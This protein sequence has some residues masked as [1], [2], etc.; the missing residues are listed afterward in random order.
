MV[1][2]THPGTNRQGLI[3]LALAAGLAAASLGVARY[4]QAPSDA[5]AEPS[6]LG[7]AGAAGADIA[8]LRRTAEAAPDD[9]R[10]WGNLAVAHAERGEFTAAVAAFRRATMI[11][12][13]QPALWS[14]LGEAL[15]M[16]S[17]GD[18]LPPAALDAFKKAL[19]LDPKDTRA[20]YF[21]AAKKDIDKDHA[22]A[23]ADWLALLADTPRGA[24]WEADLLRTIEQVGKANGISVASRIAAVNAKRPAGAPAAAQRGPSADDAAAAASMT[25][26]EQRTMIEGMVGQLEARL[27]SEAQNPE[28]WVML[29]RSRMAL[30]E[31]AKAKAALDAAIRANPGQADALRRQAEALGIK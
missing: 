5:P 27:A 23:I 26:A 19:A 4:E 3:L 31:P 7:S 17:E 6:A 21:L 25:S 9:A 29:M 16:A 8:A 13:S 15:V 2:E 12:D 18:P 20:R 11:D 14:A 22:G 30:G 28:G 1:S 10:A 24:P